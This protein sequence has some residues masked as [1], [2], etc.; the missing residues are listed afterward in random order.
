MNED[1]QTINCVAKT[2]KLMKGIISEGHTAQVCIDK[3]DGD[4]V[5]TVIK[6]DKGQEPLMR[7]NEEVLQD[8][9]KNKHLS[10]DTMHP[11]WRSEKSVY[12]FINKPK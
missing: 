10:G 5:I 11:A 7:I 12:D 8:L 3:R 6:N 1:K 4:R 2:L 9:R